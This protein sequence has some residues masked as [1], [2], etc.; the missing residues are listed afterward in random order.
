LVKNWQI[1]S[2]KM[3]NVL[4]EVMRLNDKN[5]IGIL[6]KLSKKNTLPNHCRGV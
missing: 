2:A 1:I 3:K 6:R 5:K 4:K